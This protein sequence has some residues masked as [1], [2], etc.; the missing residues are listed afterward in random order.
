MIRPADTGQDFINTDYLKG[1]SVN[2]LLRVSILLLSLFLVACFSPEPA[3]T[4][5]PANATATEGDGLVVVD[6]DSVPGRTYWIFYGEGS[7]ASL[8][9]YDR[10]LLSV[11]PPYV[12][13]GLT[14]ATQYAF[15]VT[16]SEN[17]SQVGPFTPALTATPRLLG[18]AIP[19]TIGTSL[20]VNDL[21][22]IAFGNNIY[23]TVGDAA[24][25]LI[26]PYSYP[27]EGGVTGWSAATSLPAGLTAN[28]VSV[29]YDGLR[30]MALAED[31][32]VIK[33]TD[34]DA[35]IWEAATAISSAPLMHA[36]TVGAGRYVAVGDAGAIYSNTSD[37][38]TAAWTEQ[39]SGTTDNLYAVSYI[40]GRFVAVGASGRLLTS[41]DGVSWATN[42]P[43]T[44]YD[45]RGVA[46]GAG[47]YVAVGD[48]G[49][50]VSSTDALTWVAQTNP[51]GGESFRSICFGPDLQFIAVG[52]TGVLAYSTT[53]ADGSW[54][55]S[56]AGSI[57]LNDI[58]PN[59]MFIAVGAAGAN[60]SG[61]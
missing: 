47:S 56:N 21:H 5:A 36:F 55:T 15:A 58:Y 11:Q 38:V 9:V 33:S 19:W 18:P 23:V 7:N 27:S 28:L 13:T 25:V 10:I 52:T 14:N 16:S 60:V 2:F 3:P 40:N 39:I 50:I 32:S 34:T 22:S 29:L 12:L 46:Y 45:L 48:S 37:G 4:D 31:G 26:A 59:Q 17:G 24:T 44:S 43:V 41:S 61:K 30:F 57:N 1:K 20:S 8:D 42:D 49:A 54:A 6:W 51:A 35:L 53:G